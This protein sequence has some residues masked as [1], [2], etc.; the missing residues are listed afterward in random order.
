MI[1]FTS[2]DHRAGVHERQGRR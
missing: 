1:R 2:K